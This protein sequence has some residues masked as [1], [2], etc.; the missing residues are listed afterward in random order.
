MRR[1]L[2]VGAVL[3]IA[4]VAAAIAY[5][6]AAQERDYR[7]LLARGDA[8]LHDDQTFGAIEAYS[9]AMALRPESML[10]HLPR[11]ATY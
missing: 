6:T 5:Q 10:A 11:G 1:S 8:A 3:I 4:A 2:L 9:G 7:A